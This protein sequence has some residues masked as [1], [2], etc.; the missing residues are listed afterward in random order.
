MCND[1]TDAVQM[2]T[3][4][5]SVLVLIILLL[6]HI[7][8]ATC[9]MKSSRHLVALRKKHSPLKFCYGRDN[10]GPSL[11]NEPTKVELKETLEYLHLEKRAATTN[12]DT[13]PVLEGR[14]VLYTKTGRPEATALTI[15]KASNSPVSL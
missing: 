12:G 14:K 15:I 4:L 3:G 1:A 10:P 6:R 7:I 9:T 2:N 8:K 11:D 5:N 13:L